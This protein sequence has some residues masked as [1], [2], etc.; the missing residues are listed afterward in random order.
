MSGPLA[1]GWLAW[2]ERFSA[3]GMRA[4]IWDGGLVRGGQ[5]EELCGPAEGLTDGV[6]RQ[7]S[8]VGLVPRHLPRLPAWWERCQCRFRHRSPRPARETPL[9]CARTGLAGLDE[10]SKIGFVADP[11]PDR[12][13]GV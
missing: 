11:V 9:A 12:K 5:L 6:A 7:L 10:L 2:E 1:D 13:S 3:R 8:L 4:G